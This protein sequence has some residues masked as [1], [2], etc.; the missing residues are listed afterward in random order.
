MN[1][2]KTKKRIENSIKITLEPIG[3]KLKVVEF[4]EVFQKKNIYYVNN[5][6]ILK[7]KKILLNLGDEFLNYK[8]IT[9]NDRKKN[10]KKI[11]EEV[12]WRVQTELKDSK[13]FRFIVK[14]VNKDTYMVIY[15]RTEILEKVVK[16]FDKESTVIFPEILGSYNYWIFLQNK[17][18]KKD[19]VLIQMK[20]NKTQIIFVK[21]GYLIDIVSFNIGIDNYRKDSESLVIPAFSNGVKDIEN[22]NRFKGVNLQWMREVKYFIFNNSKISLTDIEVYFLGYENKILN[23]DKLL[24]SYLELVVN[25]SVVENGAEEYLSLIGNLF[26]HRGK[27]RKKILIPKRKKSIE[28]E[29]LLVK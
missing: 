21:D 25:S 10:F 16:N 26:S 3:K 28:K 17:R 5:S 6:E 23:L 8:F 24:G 27:Y 19:N 22:F 7:R 13:N 20:E 9:M 12:V 15:Y 14:K 4:D 2:R 29:T 1:R 11:K 18:R